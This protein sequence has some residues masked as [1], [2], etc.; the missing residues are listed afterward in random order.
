MAYIVE[1][2]CYKCNKSYLVNDNDQ[3]LPML[4]PACEKAEC[5]IAEDN[6]IEEL[7]NLSIEERMKKIERW[8]YNHKDKVTV[9]NDLFY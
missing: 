3:S 2:I 6:Y 5:M 7:K 8:I 4:C 1:K 9:L